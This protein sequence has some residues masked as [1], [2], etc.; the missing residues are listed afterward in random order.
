MVSHLCVCVGGVIFYAS[1]PCMCSVVNG[2]GFPLY[3]SDI[4]SVYHNNGISDGI[5]DF[6]VRYMHLSYIKLSFDEYG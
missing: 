4:V 3:L 2:K 5:I 6:F 1:F